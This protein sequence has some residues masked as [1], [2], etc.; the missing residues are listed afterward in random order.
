MAKYKRLKSVAH[1]LGHSFLSD[2]NGL[3]N[4]YEFVPP[5][6]YQRARELGAASVVVDFLHE[7]IDPE[8]LKT[9]MLQTSIA[10]YRKQ[11]PGLVESQGVPLS[12]ITSAVLYL[13]FDLQEQPRTGKFDLLEPPDFRCRVEIVDDRG[14]THVGE[15]KEWMS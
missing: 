13:W 2:S 11:L 9:P 4:P 12:A 14:N 3:G 10:W 15:P 1:N 8:E 5:H 7:R 6:L